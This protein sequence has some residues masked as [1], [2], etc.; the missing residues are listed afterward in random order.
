MKNIFKDLGYK[1]FHRFT[2][3][4][5]I[6]AEEELLA[7]QKYYDRWSSGGNDNMVINQGLSH[8]G[9]TAEGEILKHT[10]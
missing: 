7:C 2:T 4:K 8:I 10:K 5:P 6:D 3:Y 1:Y 9:W